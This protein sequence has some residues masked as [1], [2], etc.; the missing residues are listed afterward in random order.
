MGKPTIR[1]DSLG[2]LER[3][4]PKGPPP[5]YRALSRVQGETLAYHT[6]RGYWLVRFLEEAHPGFVRGFLSERHAPAAIE[7][8]LA[9]RLGLQP[10]S[11]WNEIDHLVGRHFRAGGI[12]PI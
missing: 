4:Q 10:E 5:S 12:S 8:Q 3:T 2:L 7:R 9:E 11:L 6:V 1:E